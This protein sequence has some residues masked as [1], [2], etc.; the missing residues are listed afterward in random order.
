MGCIRVHYLS[1]FQY[2]LNLKK[3]PYEISILD[4]LGKILIKL[5]YNNCKE[6]TIIKI[7]YSS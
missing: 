2:K 5:Y 1:A 4:T 6:I 7:I 3:L